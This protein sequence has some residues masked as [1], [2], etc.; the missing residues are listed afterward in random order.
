MLNCCTR[1]IIK[2]KMGS[3]QLGSILLCIL[4]LQEVTRAEDLDLRDKRKASP[5]CKEGFHLQSGKTSRVSITSGDV[6]PGKIC[7][8]V[9]FGDTDC[10]PELTC[11]GIN[12]KK[13]E[14]CGDE[15]LLVSDGVGGEL[16]VCGKVSFDKPLLASGKARDL[17]VRYQDGDFGSAPFKCEAKCSADQVGLN[18][19]ISFERK[20]LSQCVCGLQNRD[21]RIVGGED[22]KMNEFP[23]QAAIV[24]AGTRQPKCG[25]SVLND[26]YILTAT[27]CFW[28]DGMQ[29]DEVEVLIHAYILDMTKKDI[30]KDVKLGEM[31]S[32]RG[33]G[34]NL[35]LKTDE[36]EKT[37]RYRVAEIIMH[38][39]F[40]E[41]YDYDFALLR[42]EKKIDLTASDSPTPICLPPPNLPD[43]T[44]EDTNPWVVGWGMPDEN[45]GG[46]TRVLQ[47]L[48][49]PIL[50]LKRCQKWLPGLVTQRMICAGFEEGK[51]DACTGDSGGP[52]ILKQ[53]NKQWWQIGIVS[54][55]EG[56]AGYHKPGLYSRVTEM[57]QWLSYQANKHDAKWCRDK[58]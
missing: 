57:H 46:T 41:Q 30:A 27:H 54:W 15:Y 58:K 12:L 33:S 7:E 42:L 17:F 3:V 40:T 19:P 4:V 32:I 55:G 31:G 25:A 53:S 9:I 28:F 16:K 18:L 56:C 22:A 45:A 6:K 10:Q 51:K 13:S 14:D 52:L 49:V 2:F 11:S 36:E 43:A 5:G 29:A 48:S 26:R 35:K 47:K 23:W 50:P 39:L 8:W 24:Y 20:E 38:P 21:D 44:F 34:Y 37:Q 1:V